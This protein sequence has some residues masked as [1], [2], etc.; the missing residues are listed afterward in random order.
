M[1]EPKRVQQLRQRVLIFRVLGVIFVGIALVQLF[2]RALPLWGYLVAAVIFL[3]YAVIVGMP[4]D[5]E[6]RR[7]RKSGQDSR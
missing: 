5:R 1:G 3:G 4:A 2:T 7:L 6:L